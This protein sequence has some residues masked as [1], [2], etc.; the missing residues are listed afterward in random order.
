[1]DVIDKG[2]KN[3]IGALN[4]ANS[5]FR[6]GMRSPSELKKISV[7]TAIQEACLVSRYVPKA[8]T[9]SEESGD[10]EDDWQ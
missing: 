2:T 8:M 4:I 7:V 10:S 6:D 9:H 5:S 1:M 3:R